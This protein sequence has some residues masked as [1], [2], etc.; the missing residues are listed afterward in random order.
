MRD[1]HN[2]QGMLPT[3]TTRQGG[4]E[5]IQIQL[6]QKRARLAHLKSLKTQ[7]RSLHALREFTDEEEEVQLDKILENVQPIMSH[8]ASQT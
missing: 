1:D 8:N 6:Q 4:L 5:D 2:A 7:K 3:K